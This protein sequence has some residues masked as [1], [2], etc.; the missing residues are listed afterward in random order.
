MACNGISLR[1]NSRL[2]SIAY[3]FCHSE[4]CSTHCIHFLSAITKYYK[5]NSLKTREMGTSLV[6]QW[7]RTHLPMQGHTFHPGPGRFHRPGSNEGRRPQL[8]RPCS[9]TVRRPNTTTTEE[10]AHSNED[11]APPKNKSI[12]KNQNRTMAS[13]SSGDRKSEIKMSAS[14]GSLWRSPGVS[15]WSSWLVVGPHSELAAASRPFLP[16]ITRPSPSAP[17]R[18]LLG[19][20]PD[21]TRPP[22]LQDDLIWPRP[23]GLRLQH[24]FFG[25]RYSTSIQPAR[26][27][28]NS[29]LNTRPASEPSCSCGGVAPCGWRGGLRGHPMAPPPASHSGPAHRARLL[30][31]DPL[32]SLRSSLSR[33]LPL[34]ELPDLPPPHPLPHGWRACGLHSLSFFDQL[35]LTSFSK[36]EP[37]TQRVLPKFC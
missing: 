15:P 23:W 24:T 8:L 36:S 1:K 21:T 12:K 25:G 27:G 6:V 30:C 32:C 2:K 17:S 11:P 9:A 4:L 31:S 33:S 18:H 16:L 19:K 20:T 26:A 7:W 29:Y 28:D 5:L 14:P 3:W 22:L 37:P 35:H 34:A 10:P 13:H